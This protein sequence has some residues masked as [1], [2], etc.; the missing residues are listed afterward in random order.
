M[1]PEE[2]MDDRRGGAPYGVLLAVV[3]V[4]VMAAPM[5]LGDRGEAIRDLI[6]EMLSPIGLLLLPIGLLLL[7]QFLSSERGSSI[8][9][10]TGSP[11]TIHR[12]TGSPVGVALFLLL[13]LFLLYNRFSIFNVG[14]DDDSGD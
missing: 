2:M 4:A 14:G 13:L 3:V 8:F 12:I 9:S 10:A 11:D 6:S 1:R 7:I 5:L